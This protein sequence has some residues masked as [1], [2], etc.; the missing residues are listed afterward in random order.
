MRT[1]QRSEANPLLTEVPQ[2]MMAMTATLRRS[3]LKL[4]AYRGE[5]PSV[6]YLAQERLAIQ[7]Q[8]WLPE[9]TAA[10]V[11]LSLEREVL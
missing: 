4:L 8:G 11:T 5:G 1:E 2:L 3:T 10:C 6:A 7:D 9:E